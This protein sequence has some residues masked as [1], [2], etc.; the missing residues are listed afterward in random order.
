MRR[1]FRARD[2][3]NRAGNLEPGEVYPDRLAPIIRQDAEGG[4]GPHPLG[5]ALAPSVLETARDPG[6]INL[7][8]TA[9]P[10]RRRGEA[11]CSGR[12]AP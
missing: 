3:A 4:T 11:A 2:L 9:S 6:V 5:D 12:A 7:R 8:N 1:L 10:H